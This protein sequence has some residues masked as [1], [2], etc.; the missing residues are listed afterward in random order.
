MNKL[1]YSIVIGAPREQV[2]DAMLSDETYRQWTE[3]FA[4]GSHYV[5]DWT[6]GSEI[7]FLGPGETSGTTGMV[8]R[9]RE[10][11][12]HEYISIEHLGVIENGVRRAGG[13]GAGAWSGA[14]ENYT[15]RDHPD[16]TEVL[17]DMDTLEE[18]AAA[19][20][21]MWPKA[22]E[23]LKAIAEARAGAGARQ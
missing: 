13:E 20:E 10:N 1:E 6:E 9:I 11:R 21:G 15:F 2:W 16:G 8:S 23:T 17:V 3:P 4:P 7:L 22:L 14:L 19:F 5:G 12:R 18:H